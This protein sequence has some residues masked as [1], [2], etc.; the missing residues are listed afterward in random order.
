M[1]SIP[2]EHKSK[3]KA[4]IVRDPTI[5]LPTILTETQG[6]HLL[7][8]QA[9][10]GETTACWPGGWATDLRVPGGLD[11]WLCTAAWVDLFF[12]PAA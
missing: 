6:H 10:L 7:H 1:L 4:S 8:S 5:A 3:H 12:L 2:F 9:R 11:Q